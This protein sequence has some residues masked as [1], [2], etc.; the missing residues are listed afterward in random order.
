RKSGVTAATLS[1]VL[2]LGGI[3]LLLNVTGIMHVGVH[4]FA[5]VAL[6]ITGAGLALSAWR[7]RAWGLIPVALVLTGLMVFSSARVPRFHSRLASASSV[8]SHNHGARVIHPTSLADLQ[9]VYHVGAG[10][11]DVD[12]T[13]VRIPEGT[14]HVEVNV[15]L[16]HAIITV[17]RDEKVVVV[18]HANLGSVSVFGQNQGGSSITLRRSSLPTAPTGN[19]GGGGQISDSGSGTLEL[20]ARVGIGEVE[21]V[22]AS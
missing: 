10:D 21:V 4:G 3:L 17:P 6:I 14:R 16:G 8:G 2:V 9:S 18:G 15:G 19:E 7:G 22:R 13:S 20:E 5:A 11:L 1:S 12:L